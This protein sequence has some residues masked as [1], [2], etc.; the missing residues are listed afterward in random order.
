MREIKFRAW[1]KDK[2]MFY[3]KEIDNRL[4]FVMEN[5]EEIKYPLDAEIACG[6]WDIMQF[7]GLKDKNG[8]EI[9]EGDYCKQIF[10]CN[11]QEGIVKIESTRG[12]TI[13]GFPAWPHNIEIIGNIYENPELLEPQK[14]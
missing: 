4:W 12:T 2:N 13:G 11:I 8:K 9:Y 3:Q 14:G 5:D 6:H 1:D 7:T 10:S